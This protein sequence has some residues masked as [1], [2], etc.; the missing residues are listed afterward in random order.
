[1]ASI[2]FFGQTGVK[3]SKAHISVV[4]ERIGSPQAGD[5]DKRD[6]RRLRRFPDARIVDVERAQ[7]LA[8]PAQAR[9]YEKRPIVR[10]NQYDDRQAQRSKQ[11]HLCPKHLDVYIWRGKHHREAIEHIVFLRQAKLAQRLHGQPAPH[12]VRQYGDRADVRITC[13]R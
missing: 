11:L 10:R 1:M 6:I 12:G 9:R 7:T 3:H 4:V 5:I 13:K 8:C 2:L